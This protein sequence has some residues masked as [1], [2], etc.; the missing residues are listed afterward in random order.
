MSRGS[1]PGKVSI[2]LCAYR[3]MTG[4]NAQAVIK[5]TAGKR[6]GRESNSFSGKK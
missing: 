4:M 5:G 2:P 3:P 6:N 1:E